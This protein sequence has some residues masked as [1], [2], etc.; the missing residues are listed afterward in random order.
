MKL[1]KKDISYYARKNKIKIE[2][3]TIVKLK[4]NKEIQTHYA[5]LI[6]RGN[7]RCYSDWLCY[8]GSYDLVICLNKK[9]KVIKTYDDVIF[10]VSFFADGKIKKYKKPQKIIVNEQLLKDCKEFVIWND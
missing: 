10:D 9:L 6:N 3:Y 8:R 7:K 4:S 1:F 5:I 2:N